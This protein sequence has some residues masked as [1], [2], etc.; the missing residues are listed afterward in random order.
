MA[1]L[2]NDEFFVE[3]TKLDTPMFKDNKSI[4]WYNVPCSFDIET[5]S[6]YQDGI[7]A[8]ENKRA[9]MYIWQFG[10]CDLVTYGRT[11]DEFKTFVSVLTELLDLDEK[12]RL[13]CYV[14]NLPYEWQ[15]I[16]KHFE[17]DTVFFLEDRK[18]VK[19]RIGGL[20][21][22]C[23][24]KLSGGKSLANVGKDLQTH[25]VEKKV[26]DLDYNLI[27]TPLTPLMETELGY[28]EYDIRVVNAYIAEKI[29]QDKN[30]SRIPL[31]NTG[32]VREFCRKACF[33]AVEEVQENYGGAYDGILGV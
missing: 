21:F 15:F 26:G 2:S 14:H 11:W 24:L 13:V 30:V 32:Y 19:A 33:R 29:E 4:L 28:C 10:I 25:K 22:R 3:L 17:W 23:S 20:E 9:I 31:T 8:P 7:V 1:M 27:R 6:F 16:R 5:S 12:C 18:P